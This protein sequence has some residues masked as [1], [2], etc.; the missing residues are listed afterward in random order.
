[1]I[2]ALEEAC[3]DPAASWFPETGNK[4]AFRAFGP[5]VG[6]SD[7]QGIKDFLL[8]WAL[9][10]RCDQNRST[11]HSEELCIALIRDLPHVLC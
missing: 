4:C 9:T 8:C 5:E 11:L 3:D 1:M 7:D 2:S 6:Y 10:S